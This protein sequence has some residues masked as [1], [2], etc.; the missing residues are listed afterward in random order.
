MKPIVVDAMGG[1]NAPGPEVVGALA[2]VREFG[3]DVVLAGDEERL[4]NELAQRGEQ[5]NPKIQILHA[6]QVVTM[7]DSP[8]QAF[9]KKTDSSL[10]VAFELVK[11]G[12]AAGIVSAGNSGAVLGHA[13]FVLRRIKGVERPAIVTVFPTPTDQIVICDVGAN[14][15]VKPSMLAQFGI[16]GANF[17]HL[18]HGRKRP[19]VG[20]LSNGTELKKGT[21]L[22]REAHEIL[23]RASRLEGCF[24]DYHGYVEGSEIFRGTVDV[25]CT[26]G[27]TGNVVL[28]L[29]E[30]IVEAIMQLT[31]KHVKSSLMAKIGGILIRPAMRRLKQEID[32]AETGGALL[33][34][35]QGVVILAHGRSDEHALKNAIKKCE[36]VAAANLVQKLAVS[37]ASF[38]E[39]QKNESQENNDDESL[40]DSLEEGVE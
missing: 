12:D 3:G 9:R 4:N 17:D 5:K 36:S 22:T 2:Y 19:R 33:A 14:V 35:V 32:Y 18:V 13:L 16:L 26:D 40:K 6:S 10:R 28:K 8:A 7:E 24:F 29:G 39:M 21:T 20:L 34:G 11:K 27:F 38:A 23:L 37:M 30:G 31:K 15:D 25:V 1:D